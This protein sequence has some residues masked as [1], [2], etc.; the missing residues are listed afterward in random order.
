MS[1]FR[2]QAPKYKIRTL[3]DRGASASTTGTQGSSGN[4]SWMSVL[5]LYFSARHR[6]MALAAVAVLL[7]CCAAWP[8][9][10]G[11]WQLVTDGTWKAAAPQEGSD[12]LM[13]GYDDT[14]W[15]DASAPS[16]M[17]RQ[18]MMLAPWARGARALAIWDAEPQ[19]TTCL[20]KSLYLERV[21]QRA[22]VTLAADDDYTLYVNGALVADNS[23]RVATLNAAPCDITTS[24][25]KGEN[26]IGI[27]GRDFGGQRCVV[28]VLDFV[29]AD[30]GA[31]A[32]AMESTTRAQHGRSRR[33]FLLIAAEALALAFAA[34]ALVHRPLPRGEREAS[35]SDMPWLRVTLGAVLVAALA[36]GLFVA[37]LQACKVEPPALILSV[38]AA[39]E[40]TAL[41][42]LPATGT[43]VGLT[44][45]VAERKRTK[46]TLVSD[47]S[48]LASS[49][50]RPK[51]TSVD[52][53][54]SQ[55]AA[56]EAPYRSAWEPMRQPGALVPGIKTEPIWSP[57]NDAVIH[58]RKSFNLDGVPISPSTISLAVDD[59]YDL[60]LNGRFVGQKRGGSIFPGSEYDVHN[61][62][63]RGMNTIA[64]KAIDRGG[65]RAV[66]ACLRITAVSPQIG[67]ASFISS[68]N[69]RLQLARRVQIGA[70]IG[71]AV[72]TGAIIVLLLRRSRR[73]KAGAG[74]SS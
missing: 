62:L 35:S 33:L 73:L 45:F 70:L 25:V 8:S 63:Q 27:V 44:T 7:V 13:P 29:E 46:F 1:P 42:P 47:G 56:V 50:E 34:F 30:G 3:L 71:W 52:F 58:L 16:P 17:G 5:I 23:D 38:A 48:W 21:P 15:P 54:D 39:G 26:V 4:K 20:R 10:A 31:S 36:V 60:Y 74:E 12:W 64:L 40:A 22:T 11:A 24:L 51:W 59:D 37:L 18:D 14:A 69:E 19:E 61:L 6:S 65:G 72:L 53:D 9:A 66:I 55:W 28:G 32:A 43:Q 67:D 2:C 57:G 41:A 68:L 49:E